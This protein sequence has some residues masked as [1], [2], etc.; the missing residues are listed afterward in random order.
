MG[1]F[2]GKYNVVNKRDYQIGAGFSYYQTKH[3]QLYEYDL[4][5]G[6]GNIYTR[7]RLDSFSLGLDYIPSKYWVDSEEY[8]LRHQFKPQVSWNM[9]ENLTT[10]LFI[11]YYI[12]DHLQDDERD[13]DTSN[14]FLESFFSI[15][16][17]KS[18]IFAGI[19]YEDNDASN[20]DYCYAQLKTKLGLSL[21]LFRDINVVLTG[22]YD[23]KKYDNVDSSHLVKR[24]GSKYSGS[25]TL[26]SKLFWSWLSILLEYSY[27]DNNSNIDIYTYKRSTTTLS[28]LASF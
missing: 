13:G 6:I 5:A 26:S 15:I 19:G 22:R 23:D 12:N 1:L 14:L 7:Y 11:N 21:T 8:M 3:H 2:S 16:P 28:L 17:G 20:D 18:V 10:K 24:E 9:N 27:V 25:V 4:K